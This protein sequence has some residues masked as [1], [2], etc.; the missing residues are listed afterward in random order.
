SATIACASPLAA[1]ISATTAARGPAWR[2]TSTTRAPARPRARPSAR[3]RP[4][5]P[6]VTRAFF[7]SRWFMGLLL[8]R[9][10]AAPD[11]PST[12]MLIYC[13]EATALDPS[14]SDP[15]IRG[16]Q[17]DASAGTSADTSA[18]LGRN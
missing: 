7:L 10:D 18:N 3:P 15:A 5:L 14:T 2:A 17:G 11:K 4:W 16:G 1:R 13:Q 6:P 12:R 9:E 8:E